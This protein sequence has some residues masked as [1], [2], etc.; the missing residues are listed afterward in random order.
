MDAM[1]PHPVM[2]IFDQAGLRARRACL[3]I[4]VALGL[5]GLGEGSGW[6][7]LTAG[8]GGSRFN[9]FRCLGAVFGPDGPDGPEIQTYARARIPRGQGES[10]LVRRSKFQARPA[11]PAQIVRLSP[12]F[13]YLGP[14]KPTL[15]F[16]PSQ[17]LTKPIKPNL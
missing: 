6:A 11:R 5:D 9:G 14:T 7:R 10:C 17:P 13:H 1:T 16:K 8:S 3:A 4:A 2:M 15:V 12:R